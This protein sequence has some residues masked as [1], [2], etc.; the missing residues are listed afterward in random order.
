MKA[1]RITSFCILS[2]FLVL[3]CFPAS[4]Q[5]TGNILGNG[6]PT[7]RA[8]GSGTFFAPA[9]ST[10]NASIISGNAASGSASI[11][12]MPLGGGASGIVTLQDGSG[13]PIASIFA[14]N[15]PIRI[16]DANSETVTPSAVSISQCPAGNL[17]VGSSNVCA[18][19]TATFASTHGAASNPV[20][21]SGDGGIEEAVNDAAQNGGGNVYFEADCGNL[22][23][24]TGGVT[25]TTVNCQ[26]PLYYIST[27]GSAVVKT[28][29][30]TAT[31]FSL[32]TTTTTTSFVNACASLTAG[33]NCL[34]TTQIP[35]KV[36]GATTAL[37]PVLVT[38][39]GTPAAG[40]VHAKVWG[41][42]PVQSAQ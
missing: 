32:G 26:V 8:D 38:T 3:F 7:H 24:N 33:L 37:T 19:I 12:V 13:I 41:Y 34:T 42:T 17:G 27:G 21:A 30:T 28:T 36:A 29:I 25:T 5:Q 9:Y 1:F 18:T 11:T 23:L 15:V 39:T 14:T 35:T 22:T 4:A 16:N 2:L 40:V 6:N 10:W 20:V 31:A